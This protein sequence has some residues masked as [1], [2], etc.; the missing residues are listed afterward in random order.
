AEVDYSRIKT[1]LDQGWVDVVI[2]DIEEAFRVA[3]EHMDKKESL[4]IAYYGN[5]V[6]LL[7]YA[8]NNNIHIDLLSDQTSCHVPYD[9]G[10][11]PPGVTVEERTELLR[12][13]KEKFS[14]LVN[15]SLIHHF[16]LIKELV[17]RGTYFFDYGNSFM[18]A[19]FDAGAKDIAKNGVDESEGFIFP[20]YV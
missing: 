19:V 13:D 5:I 20:S 16:E 7:E 18:K 11:C 15:K 9:G 14:E 2:E 8:V 17:N 10:Y 6:D 3:K 12:S 1:R 4:A